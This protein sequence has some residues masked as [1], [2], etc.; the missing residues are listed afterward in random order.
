MFGIQQFGSSKH[1]VIFQLGEMIE[2]CRLSQEWRM[3]DGFCATKRDMG[4]PIVAIE[5]GILFTICEWLNLYQQKSL[6]PSLCNMLL[7]RSS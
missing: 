7:F 4:R 2:I 5:T 3:R 1:H 6:N